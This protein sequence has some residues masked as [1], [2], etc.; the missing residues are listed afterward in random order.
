[1][2]H[3]DIRKAQARGSADFGWLQSRH[4]F[5]FGSYHDPEHPGFSELLVIN[6]D[7]VAAGRGF[8]QH[9]H[10]DMEIFS[11]VLDGALA[12]KDSM[13]NG[14][15]ILPGDV[16]MMS[17]GLGI[18]HSEFN[19]SATQAVHFLQIWIVPNRNGVAP[20]YQQRHFSN[21][22]KQGKLLKI[23][24]SEV[25]AAWLHV[26]QD[27][28]VYAGRFDGFE[29]AQFQLET[30]RYGY[31]HVASGALELNGTLLQAGD[32][33]KIREPGVI[34][35]AGGQHAEVLV[36]DLPARELPSIR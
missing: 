7:H 23:I 29:Q 19:P 24:G 27:A 22:D 12:H 34:A 30:G 21:A 13:G 26:Y 33:A 31:V 28:S 11:F 15:T 6:D 2:T 20:R 17:A 25:N 3:M 10:R 1:M 32:A 5:S 35:L 18:T 36:F 16:Q 14:T 9:P 8:G 4:S